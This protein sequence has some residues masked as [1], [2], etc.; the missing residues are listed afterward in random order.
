[1]I[2]PAHCFDGERVH[3][4]VY[5]DEDLFRL[6]RQR[7]FARTWQY[8][9]HESQLPDTGDY[10]TAEIAGQPVLLTRRADGGLAAMFNRCAHKGAPLL[11]ERQGCAGGA[12]RCPYHGWSYH[13]DG[14]LIGVPQRPEYA[15]SAFEACESARGLAPV[16]CASYRGF[17]FVRVSPS[18]EDFTTQAG[19]L[20]PTLDLIA[21]RSPGGRM[22]VSGPCLRMRL[23]CNWKLYLENINDTLHVL[24]AHASAAGAASTVWGAPP[25][26]TPKPMAIEQLLPFAEGH[27]FF[28]RMGGRLLPGGHTI[29]GTRG[30]IHA[31]YGAL[32]D[33][34]RALREAHGETRAEAVLAFA[35][36]NVILY[37]GVALKASP[38]TIRV[39]RPISA[40]ETLLEVWALAPADGPGTLRQRGITYNR[41]VFSPMSVVAHDDIHLWEA[42]QRAL[43]AGGNEWVSLQRAYPG[44]ETADGPTGEGREVAGTDE[45]LMRHQYAAWRHWM[46]RPEETAH[47][48]AR[49]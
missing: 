5:L 38:L 19:A 24:T 27:A 28:E 47:P 31:G 18:G 48:S 2:D 37:P 45:A 3:R 43:A 36:Q 34:T 44:A 20:L 25:P 7:L 33:Y 39:L 6:E 46:T 26:D 35:P 22:T 29:L 9:A 21:D 30:S 15:R 41:L 1:M 42:T 14:R 32:D 23:K 49:A 8:I 10:V 11:T 4:A 12:L 16:A 17:V 40:G 13:L